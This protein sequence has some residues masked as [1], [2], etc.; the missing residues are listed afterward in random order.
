MI[1]RIYKLAVITA[2]IHLLHNAFLNHLKHNYLCLFVADREDYICRKNGTN[3]Y[4]N[5]RD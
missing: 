5:S 1:R 3:I 4:W 2:L